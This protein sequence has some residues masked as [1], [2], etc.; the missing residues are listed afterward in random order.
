MI[1]SVTP[2]PSSSKKKPP[3]KPFLKWAGAK[4]RVFDRIKA[5]YG[6]YVPQRLVEPFLGSGATALNLN[7]TSN[8]LADTNQHLV[9]V[10]TYLQKEQNA[11]IKD[12]AALFTAKNNTSEK[13]YALREEFNKTKDARRRATIFIYLNRHGFNGLCR[14][15]SSG[16]FNVP[17]GKYA[18]PY[19]PADE[20]RQFATFLQ[21]ATVVQSDFRKVLPLTGAGDFVYCDPPY[22]ALGATGFTAYATGGFSDADQRELAR[23]AEE[24]A[25]R[26]ALVAISNHDTAGIRKIYRDHGAKICGFLVARTISCDGKNRNKAKEIIAVFGGAA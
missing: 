19:F 11:F 3:L 5:S 4:T 25:A 15:N 13:Y 21:S 26:G 23:L 20:M 10:F 6:S 14:Y 1:T 18:A 17:F 9:D 8:L 12:C 2:T 16:G 7:L 22:V 24:A